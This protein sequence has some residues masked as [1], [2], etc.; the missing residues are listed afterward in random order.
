MSILFLWQRP[1]ISLCFFLNNVAISLTEIVSAGC[2]PLTYTVYYF[3][4]LTST[5][6]LVE[7]LS[8]AFN[9]LKL[10]HGFQRLFIPKSFSQ[11]LKL[12]TQISFIFFSTPCTLKPLHISRIGLL[13]ILL[14]IFLTIALWSFWEIEKKNGSKNKMI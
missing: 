6:T 1:C 11:V 2:L 14:R 5:P 10:A 12:S 3:H 7:K 4:A 8:V 9:M 13:I